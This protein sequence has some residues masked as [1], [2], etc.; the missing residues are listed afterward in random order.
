MSVGY[1][2]EGFLGKAEKETYDDSSGGSRDER[3][4]CFYL[5]T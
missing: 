1:R 4:E 3:S 2:D 5:G